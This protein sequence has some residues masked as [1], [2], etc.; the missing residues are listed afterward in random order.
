MHL[1]LS[2]IPKS[3]I[4]IAWSDYVLLFYLVSNLRLEGQQD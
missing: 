3:A 4:L 2:L 1:M